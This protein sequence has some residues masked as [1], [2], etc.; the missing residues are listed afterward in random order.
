MPDDNEKKKEAGQWYE[1]ATLGFVFPVAIVVGFGIGYGLDHV[2]HSR[3][4]MTIIFTIVG[5][6]AAFVQL[7]RAGSGSDGG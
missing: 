6:A 4:W 3:P 5:I 1:A 2:F 7:F